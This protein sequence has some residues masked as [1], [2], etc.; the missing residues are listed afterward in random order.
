MEGYNMLT[1]K[2]NDRS[3][4]AAGVFILD[5]VFIRLSYS[6]ALSICS[7]KRWTPSSTTR[8]SG[9]NEIEESSQALK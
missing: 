5:V 9:A 6:Y 8:L 7:R 4:I 3:D 1:V 2:K